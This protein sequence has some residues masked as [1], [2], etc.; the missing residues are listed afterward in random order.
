MTNTLKILANIKRYIIEEKESSILSHIKPCF[1][2]SSS[3][4][5]WAYT[6][7]RDERKG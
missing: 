4:H 2:Y 7:K 3:L 1:P 6:P 5:F